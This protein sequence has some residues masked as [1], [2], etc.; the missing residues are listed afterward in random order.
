MLIP[1]SQFDGKEW[2]Y[3]FDIDINGEFVKL[4][5]NRGDD[6]WM[7]AQ[8]WIWKNGLDQAFLDE[9][10][11]HLIVNTPGNVVSSNSG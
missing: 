2:D 10:A 7:A 11:N 5:F 6:P 9:T 8:Q 3:L 1:L 4:P